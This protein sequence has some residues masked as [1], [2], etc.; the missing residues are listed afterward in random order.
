MVAA[1]SIRFARLL[2][3]ALNPMSP[4][5]KSSYDSE[6]LS[7]L[8]RLSP[9]CHIAK[10]CSKVYAN[11]RRQFTAFPV[12]LVLFHLPLMFRPYPLAIQPGPGITG[13]LQFPFF[14]QNVII[15]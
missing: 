5:G 13:R 8:D 15:L 3:G 1:S 6:E 10:H 2:A 14:H 4:E 11:R 7:K 12:K 9:F